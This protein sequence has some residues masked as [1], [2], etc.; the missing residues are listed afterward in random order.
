LRAST[1]RIKNDELKALTNRERILRFTLIVL[2]S[3]IVLAL[4]TWAF[5]SWK[6]VRGQFRLAIRG[7]PFAPRA[8]IT[9]F[10]RCG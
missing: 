1:S 9:A 7:R 5:T 6:E 10:T 3:V 4:S 8:C 2:V